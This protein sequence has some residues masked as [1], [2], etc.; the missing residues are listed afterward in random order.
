MLHSE[1]NLNSALFQHCHY[2]CSD[3]QNLMEK[4]R[5]EAHENKK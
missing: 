2:K 4:S 5:K 3:T 1:N